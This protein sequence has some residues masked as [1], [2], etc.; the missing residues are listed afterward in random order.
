MGTFF[1]ARSAEG[2]F[3]QPSHIRTMAK[4]GV[5]HEIKRRLFGKNEILNTSAIPPSKSWHREAP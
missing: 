1:K 2:H 3:D 4:G 5:C